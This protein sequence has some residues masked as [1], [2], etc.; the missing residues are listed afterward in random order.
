ME[1]NCVTLSWSVFMMVVCVANPLDVTVFLPGTPGEPGR[2][3]IA[4]RT[5]V[6]EEGKR[7]NCVTH[8]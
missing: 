3:Y 5:D 4:H 6:C 2:F 1:K 7:K 8:S